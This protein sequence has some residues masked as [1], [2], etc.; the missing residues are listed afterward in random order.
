MPS[1]KTLSPTVSILVTVY[2]REA[3]LGETL[4]SILASTFE[5]YEVVIVDD[6]SRDRS[7]TIAEAYAA[8]D[9]R[10]RFHVNESNLGDYPNRNRA[11][12]L[13]RGRYLKYLDADDLIYPYSL[14]L[15]VHALEDCPEAALGLSLNFSDPDCP[16][17]FT[18]PP[19]QVFRN[20]FRGRSIL[21]VGPSASIIRR[22]A[23]EEV[24]GFSG[25]QFI[26]DSE[27]WFK[28]ADRWPVV[29]L[30]PALVWWRQHEG[31]QIRLEREH[32]EILG[33]RFQLEREVIET[34]QH[35]RP[36][37]KAFA[38]GRAKQHHARRILA[39]ATKGKRLKQAIYLARQSGMSATELLKGLRPYA[40]S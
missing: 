9:R 19:R 4:D 26:G 22:D 37:E 21:G 7:A 6:C 18:T 3:Y 32:P 29:S 12:S 10:I 25:R 16:F 13:A 2:N 33:E 34:T 23:F 35:L 17:P 1:T 39:L 30:P 5:D 27:L 24:G 36:S 8:V 11:G 14:G 38:L 40:Q 31:Q 20:H 15:M 28:L